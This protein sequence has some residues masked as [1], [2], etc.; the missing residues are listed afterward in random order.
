MLTLSS[1]EFE[2]RVHALN[3][4][5][6]E[7]QN[8]LERMGDDLACS[9][10]NF[11]GAL[12]RSNTHVFRA[13]T[14][15]LCSF[16]RMQRCEVSRARRSVTRTASSAFTRTTD[17]ASVLA[18]RT[19]AMVLRRLVLRLSG[20]LCKGSQAEGQQSSRQNEFIR[21][22]TISPFHV[23]GCYRRKIGWTKRA[24]NAAGE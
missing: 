23:F 13:L 17:A 11:P 24:D 9:F 14:D 12:R 19:L 10:D 15:V 5:V 18:G 21:N 8:V 4:A 3:P 20:I 7:P 16:Y 6:A 1:G 22:H 2:V